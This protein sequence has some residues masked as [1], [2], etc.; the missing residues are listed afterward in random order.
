MPAMA[1]KST[2]DQKLRTLE[3][4]LGAQDEEALA[5]FQEALDMSWIYH[6][7]ALEGTML[8]F[9]ELKSAIESGIAPVERR[10]SASA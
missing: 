10:Q 6:D 2:I 1:T 9:H 4:L 8:T 3:D 5:E 7:T